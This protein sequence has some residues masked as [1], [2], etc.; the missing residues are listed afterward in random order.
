MGA[1]Q[2]DEQHAAEQAEGAEQRPEAA[3]VQVGLAECCARQGGDVHALDEVG[4]ADAEHERDD[5]RTDRGA[6]VEGI[7]PT[8]V[9]HLGAVFERDASQD[10]PHQHQEQRQ[11][12]AAEQGCVP[13]GEGREGGATSGDQPDL[14]AVPGGS[15][16]VDHH[17]AFLGI[18]AEDGIQHRDAEVE[19]LKEEEADPQHRDEQEPHNLQR[20]R[21]QAR[22]QRNKRIREH[23]YVSSLS[24]RRT[25][26]RRRSASPPSPARGVLP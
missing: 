13:A 20:R 23:V 10:Q 18:L 19:A 16:R 25:V 15:D 5:Q 8:V 1:E 9:G 4:E 22:L 14:I 2:Q 21:V 26:G 7:A 3:G 6:G 24:T 12:Q 11:V 17:P